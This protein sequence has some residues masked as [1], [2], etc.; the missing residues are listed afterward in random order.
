M[1]KKKTPF[2]KY[3]ESKS[4]N[5]AALARTTG[6]RPNR[7]SEFA[8]QDCLKMRADEI[9]LLAKAL[10][11]RPGTLLDYLLAEIKS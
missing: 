7:I 11:E 5:Q 6:I 10:G 4:I 1:T 8:T 9:Y 3:L 2:G